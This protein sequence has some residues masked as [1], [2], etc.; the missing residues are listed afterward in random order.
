[1]GKKSVRKAKNNNNTRL[2]GIDNRNKTLKEIS[3]MTPTQSEVFD[4]FADG[5][6]LFLHGVAGTGKTFISLYLALEEIMHPDS[7]FREIQIIRSVVPTRD[8][9]F[10]PGSEKQ[11]IEVFEAPYKTIVNELFKSGTAYETLRKSNLINFNSTS[12][13]RGRTFYDS[14]IIVD[15]CQ[16]MN[17]HELDSVITRLGENCLLLFCGDFRQSDFKANDEK[18]GIKNFMKIIKNMKQFS[19]IEFTESDIVRSALVKSYI[20]NKLE[21]GIV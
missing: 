8:V 1:M 5:D 15:E 20:I 17:F 4:A 2:I 11:K 12:F 9:G 16:N 18:N 3:P 13:I 21:L 14:I 10:L 7:T 6:H 19:F